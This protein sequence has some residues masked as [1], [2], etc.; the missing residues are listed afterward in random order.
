MMG[1]IDAMD[2]AGY[3]YLDHDANKLEINITTGWVKKNGPL[4]K[5]NI[6]NRCDKIFAKWV[7][8]I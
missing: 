3:L 2:T 7:S 4:W 1:K 5:E 8:G 6:K